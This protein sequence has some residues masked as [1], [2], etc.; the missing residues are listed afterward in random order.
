MPASVD[1]VQHAP[2][3]NWGDALARLDGAYSEHTLRGYRSDFARFVA[4][5]EA[6]GQTPLPASPETVAEFVADQAT[7]CL[8]ATLKRRLA[9][10]R[11]LHR[12]MRLPNPVTDEEVLLALRRAL[13]TKANTSKAGTRPDRRIARQTDHRLSRHPPWPAEPSNDRGRL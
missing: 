12:L 4:W 13:R 10:I 6:V 3:M 5:C 1:P 8:P 7:T 9:G 11:K 2:P